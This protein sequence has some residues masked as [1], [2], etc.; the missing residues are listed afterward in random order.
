MPG[1]FTSNEIIPSLSSDVASFVGCWASLLML[2]RPVW[3]WHPDP[4][5]SRFF[6][7]ATPVSCISIFPILEA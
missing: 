1:A 2:I 4:P 5:A 7:A 6:L 3:N